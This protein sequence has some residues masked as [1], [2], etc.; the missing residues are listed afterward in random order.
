MLRTVQRWHAGA[1]ASHGGRMPEVTNDGVTI[2]YE[3]VG[4]GRPLVLLHGWS[5]DR[6]WWFE[7]G[8]VDDL[9]RDHRLV[10]MD[11]RGHGASDKPHD[12]EAYHAEDFTNDVLAVADAE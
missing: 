11:L 10:I 1:S 12:W 7:P 2:R 6:T 3:A 8:Y 9:K 4:Q 5:C